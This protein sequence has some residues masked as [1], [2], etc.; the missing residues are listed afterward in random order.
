MVHRYIRSQ[1]LTLQQYTSCN[2]LLPGIAFID[3]STVW[4]PS[5]GVCVSLHINGSLFTSG[6]RPQ[7]FNSVNHF[8]SQFTLFVKNGGNSTARVVLLLLELVN[9]IV[10]KHSSSQVAT[11]SMC[12]CVCHNISLSILQYVSEALWQGTVLYQ[13]TTDSL[14]NP[15]AVGCP[16]GDTACE[17]ELVSAATNMLTVMV[18]SS[19]LL[20]SLQDHIVQQIGSGG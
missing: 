3:D 9:I 10:T 14:F 13:I 4:V 18:S 2:K 19:R 16:P 20:P 1:L 6:R 11:V 12:V 17:Q 5:E 15:A 7:L 8:L